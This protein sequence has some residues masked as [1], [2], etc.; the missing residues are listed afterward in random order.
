MTD[1]HPWAYRLVTFEIEPGQFNVAKVALDL[2]PPNDR[3]EYRDLGLLYGTVEIT[4]ENEGI[5]RQ[6]P[7]RL[8]VHP[9]PSTP[10]EIIVNL[11]HI[12]YPGTYSSDLESK[13][14]K[15]TQAIESAAKQAHEWAARYVFPLAPSD[16]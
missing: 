15:M 3:L 6:T 1:D 9:R 8:I 7:P 10:V 4:M 14:L 12:T 2:R 5:S 11:G 13:S 16:R